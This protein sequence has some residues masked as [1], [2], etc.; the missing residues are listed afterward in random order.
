M[1]N[2]TKKI[3]AYL[4]KYLIIIIPG[5]VVIYFISIMGDLS[6][7]SYNDSTRYSQNIIRAISNDINTRVPSQKEYIGEIQDYV[8]VIDAN[9]GVYAQ[10]FD[11]KGNI[12]PTDR[13]AVGFD[14]N[15]NF[16][17]KDDKN[18][19][20]FAKNANSGTKNIRYNNN[21]DINVAFSW[22]P[23]STNSD[24]THPSYLVVVGKIDP[25]SSVYKNV[26]LNF[27]I[28]ALIITLLSSAVIGYSNKFH[29][30]D[31]KKEFGGNI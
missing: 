10:V 6:K 21:I 18:F 22:I 31:D 17:V 29:T 28:A 8:G 27:I 24:G 3:I 4:V 13:V 16:S 1:K 12:I 11:N 20:S 30:D 19:M 7:R 5:V 23:N 2:K 9:E 15:S 25:L 26:I 14:E